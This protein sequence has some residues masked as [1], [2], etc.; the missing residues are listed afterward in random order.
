MASDFGVIVSPLV[1]NR[2]ADRYSFSA[3]FAVTAAPIGAV[4][5]PYRETR[6]RGG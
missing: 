2:L 1:A 3:A 4:R 6:T 5:W